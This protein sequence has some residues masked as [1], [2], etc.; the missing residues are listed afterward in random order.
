MVCAD[1]DRAKIHTLKEVGQLMNINKFWIEMV[2]S[3]RV[4]VDTNA[5][6]YS[7]YGQALFHTSLQTSFATIAAAHAQVR[8][9]ANPRTGYYTHDARD[10]ALDDLQTALCRFLMELRQQYPNLVVN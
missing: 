3:L 9:I 1:G 4:Y 8:R 5:R 6:P 7:E 2:E 10:A